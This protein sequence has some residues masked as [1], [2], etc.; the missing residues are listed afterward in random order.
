MKQYAVCEEIIKGKPSECYSIR[1]ISDTNPARFII[2][3]IFDSYEEAKDFV[4]YLYHRS[5]V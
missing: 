5:V 3:Q 1:V 4:N 2:I